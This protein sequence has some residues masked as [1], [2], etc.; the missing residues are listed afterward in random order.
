[1]VDRDD[2]GVAFEL[3]GGLRLGLEAGNV[4]GGRQILAHHLDGDD[5]LGL[6]L[7]GLV[8]DAHAPLSEFFKQ[9]EITEAPGQ[10]I[11]RGHVFGAGPRTLRISQGLGFR[12]VRPHE[13]F[14]DLGRGPEFAQFIREFWV[15]FRQSVQ[16][17]CLAEALLLGQLAQQLSQLL[18]AG[19]FGVD[20]SRSSHHFLPGQLANAA[21]NRRRARI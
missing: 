9:F 13:M 8:N 15:L 5:A 18:L 7:A 12:R 10:A 11:M 6:T 14:G 20:P 1:M 2:V 17:R 4:G 3:G 16:I 21:F 19:K